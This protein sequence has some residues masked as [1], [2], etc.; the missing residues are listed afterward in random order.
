LSA[1]SISGTT[2]TKTATTTANS[3]G[4]SLHDEFSFSGTFD[5]EVFNAIY[6]IKSVA[7][8]MDNVPIKFL[9][10]IFSHIVGIITHIFNTIFMT[11]NYPATWKTN[12]L[13]G[14][15]D[16]RPISVPPAL[17]KAME[18]IMKRQITGHIENNR[19]MTCYQSGFRAKHST[20]TALLK[21]SNDLL[22]AT[23]KKLLSILVLLDFSKA[24]D[25]VDHTLLCAKLANQH[26][27]STS[28]TGIIRSY[29]SNRTQCVWIFFC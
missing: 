1:T 23:K 10:M 15:A 28:A 29:L 25:W 12:N 9:N 16:Y 17:S 2:A 22:M 11:A 21:V 18:I 26:A 7:I 14:P 13:C 8:G 19:M 24:F 3:V 6:Q 5:L 4:P 20:T 27:F